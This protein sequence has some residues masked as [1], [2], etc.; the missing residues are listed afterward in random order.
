MFHPSEKP[1]R[2]YNYMK[3]DEE[4]YKEMIEI[5]NELLP[6]SLKSDPTISG[7]HECYENVVR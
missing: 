4:V 6:Q 5:A 1:D 3:D 7:D 2:R